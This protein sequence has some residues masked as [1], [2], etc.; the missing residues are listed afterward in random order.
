M[1]STPPLQFPDLCYFSSTAIKIITATKSSAETPQSSQ[2]QQALLFWLFMLDIQKMPMTTT[3]IREISK[4]DR[5]SL[6][7]TLAQLEE[8]RLV[9]KE[10]I[11]TTTGKGSTW[12]YTFEDAFLRKVWVMKATANGLDP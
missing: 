5:N 1:K 7:R 10:Q 11:N 2:F 4:V 8:K 12:L 9:K 6:G 3:N